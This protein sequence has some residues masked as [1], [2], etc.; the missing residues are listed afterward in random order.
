MW[1]VCLCVCILTQ[2]SCCHQ[3]KGLVLRK[4]AWN[5]RWQTLLASEETCVFV[6]MCMCCVLVLCVKER[7]NRRC[8]ALWATKAF[9]Q[10]N[11]AHAHARSHTHEN[12]SSVGLL[13]ILPGFFNFGLGSPSG[14]PE[15]GTGSL[16]SHSNPNDCNNVWSLLDSKMKANGFWTRAN[17]NAAQQH[18]ITIWNTLKD[19]FLMILVS[20]D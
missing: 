2:W 7:E 3:W 1:C 13:I 10:Y 15:R 11:P 12:Y 16:C 6:C 14:G 5:S 19:F 8:K 20:T 4:Q 9:W 18:T 17:I